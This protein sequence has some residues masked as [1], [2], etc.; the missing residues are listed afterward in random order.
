MLP[1]QWVIKCNILSNVM[2]DI[3]TCSTIWDLATTKVN[4]WFYT[5]YSRKSGEDYLTVAEQRQAGD[6]QETEK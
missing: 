6:E 1:E 4:P 3:S 5:G 2:S